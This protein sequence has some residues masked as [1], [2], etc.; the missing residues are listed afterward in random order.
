MDLL[1]TDFGGGGL[2]EIFEKRDPAAEEDAGVAHVQWGRILLVA[3][4]VEVAL[5]VVG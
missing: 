3:K 4:R 1:R 5:T 2:Q